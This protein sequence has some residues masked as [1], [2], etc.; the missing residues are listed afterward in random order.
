MA[1]QEHRREWCAKR[2]DLQGGGLPLG[3][4]LGGLRAIPGD[5]ASLPDGMRGDFF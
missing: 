3:D 2:S 1:A 4:R 5:A